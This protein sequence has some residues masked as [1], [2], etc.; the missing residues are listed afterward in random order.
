MVRA[1]EGEVN[2]SSRRTVAAQADG[3]AASPANR[4]C[5]RAHQA[6]EAFESPKKNALFR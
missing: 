2:E 5:R 1:K 3:P 4:V 6:A